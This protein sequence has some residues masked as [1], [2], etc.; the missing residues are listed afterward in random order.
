MTW[1]QA[2]EWLKLSP[3]KFICFGKF[4]MSKEGRKFF[5]PFLQAGYICKN[6]LR[7]TGVFKLTDKGIRK[8]EELKDAITI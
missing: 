4:P 5:A 8:F 3:Q 2:Y 1:Q 6:T 7:F